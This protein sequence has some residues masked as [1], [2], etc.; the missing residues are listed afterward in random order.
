MSDQT[1][2]LYAYWRSSASYR[3]RIALALKG[4]DAT[5]HPVHLVRDG[6]QQHHPEYRAINPQGLVPCL[7]HGD[8]VLTQSLAI[9][10]YLDECFPGPKLLPESPSERARARML[11]QLVAC[12]LHPLNNLR[13]LKF[14]ET[15]TG[16]GESARTDWYR[17]WTETGLRALETQ[18]LSVP[19]QPRFSVNDEPGLADCCL[20]PQLYNAQR[21]D[22]SLD[23]CDRFLSICQRLASDDRI[24]KAAPENQPD[25]E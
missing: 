19:G 22:C 10:E 16:L 13:V 14:L 1:L 7:V 3:V 18:L 9:I 11:A 2:E 6:G 21:F 12:D 5:I 4:L 8:T 24:M 15:Q 17:H 25:A 20:L 23:G